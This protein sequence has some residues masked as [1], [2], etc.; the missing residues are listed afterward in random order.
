MV[1]KR[2]HLQETNIMSRQTR[3]IRNAYLGVWRWV[4]TR[5]A[6]WPVDFEISLIDNRYVL[7]VS[8][9]LLPAELVQVIDERKERERL[10]QGGTPHSPTRLI[11]NPVL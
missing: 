9:E 7:T 4:S 10:A 6:E 11:G 8:T 1:Q 3:R 5:L 2:L